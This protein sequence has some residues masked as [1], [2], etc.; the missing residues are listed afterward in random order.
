MSSY[1]ILAYMQQYTY[2]ARRRGQHA[3]AELLH[4]H[5]LIKVATFKLSVTLSN[6]VRFCN[7]CAAGKRMK[8]ATKPIRHC[9]PRIRHVATLPS[10]IKNSSSAKILKIG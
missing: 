1:I 3:N 9:P 6:L 5:C 8:F 10:G 2:Y 4:I 7:F